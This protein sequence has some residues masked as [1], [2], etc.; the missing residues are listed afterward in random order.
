MKLAASAATARTCAALACSAGL[1]AMALGGLPTFLGEGADAP[2]QPAVL[3]V[4]LAQA[5]V[6][7][8]ERPVAQV[9]ARAKRN[10]TSDPAV[11]PA[12]HYY[13]GSELTVRPA[14]LGPIEPKPAVQAASAAGKVVARILINESGAVDRVIIESAEPAG[15]FDESVVSA[16]GAARYRP[17][18]LSGQAVKSQ[19]LVEVTF[20][21]PTELGAKSASPRP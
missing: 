8:A 3:H 10:S 21:E 1:H 6:V 13:K 15:V 18:V 14:P 11:L 9:P 20:R 2:G 4:Q 12:P 5:P 19:M 16:F 17:G 7:K